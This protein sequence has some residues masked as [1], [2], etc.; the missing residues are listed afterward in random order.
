MTTFPLNGPQDDEFPDRVVSNR[1]LFQLLDF[2]PFDLLDNRYGRLTLVFASN[3]ISLIKKY[4][5]HLWLHC[6]CCGLL[7]LVTE[8]GHR[9]RTVGAMVSDT[10]HGHIN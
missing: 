5:A 1:A 8:D 4:W 3:V 10:D 7:L 2:P 9:V 6:R